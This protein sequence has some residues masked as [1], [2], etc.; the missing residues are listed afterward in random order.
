M[1]IMNQEPKTRSVLNALNNPKYEWR[2]VSGISKEAHLSP[3][4]AIEIL[5]IL[6]AQGLVLRSNVPSQDG[7][8]LFIT[9]E[10]FN[11]RSSL[12]E[13]I[14]GAIRNRII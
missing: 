10:K 3:E 7:K 6:R 4:E 11:R 12:G 8:E 14:L 9:R 5:G 2:T 1:A 13:K